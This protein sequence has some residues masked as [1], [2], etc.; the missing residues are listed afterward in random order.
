MEVFIGRTGQSLVEEM[1]NLKNVGGQDLGDTWS[2]SVSGRENQHK[3]LWQ[4]MLF[5][6]QSG[7]RAA[8]KSW[9]WERAASDEVRQAVRGQGS[10]H[11]RGF[12][13]AQEIFAG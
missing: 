3:G 11:G 6:E 7:V 9:G 1:G 13:S 8:G 2:K 10:G 12:A 5:Q 4:K